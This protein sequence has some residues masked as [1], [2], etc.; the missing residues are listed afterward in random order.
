MEYLEKSRWDYGQIRIGE[1]LGYRVTVLL[2][3]FLLHNDYRIILMVAICMALCRMLCFAMPKV[4][5]GKPPQR[6]THLLEKTFEKQNT[7]GTDPF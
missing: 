5:G 4:S 7:S 6:K 3:S 1:T 2:I